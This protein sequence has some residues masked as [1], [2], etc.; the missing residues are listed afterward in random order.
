ML[1]QS[2]FH[3]HESPACA[4]SLTAAPLFVNVSNDWHLQT[5]SPAR[6]ASDSGLALGAYS[7]A[8]VATTGGSHSYP[9]SCD[10]SSASDPVYLRYGSRG[11]TVCSTTD[12]LLTDTQ[13]MVT[14]TGVL[15][16]L[17]CLSSTAPGGTDAMVYTARVNAANTGLTC[18]ISA[19]ATTC[20][21]GASSAA[22]SAGDRLSLEVN[23]TAAETLQHMC[24]VE[25]NF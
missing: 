23:P 12:T 13:V 22:I 16:N 19:T 3:H 10:D 7:G 20:N 4:A 25:V 5:S 11:A 24:G 2:V 1:Q 9:F 6:G 21:S 18:T 14:R 17:Y 8:V 15:Q